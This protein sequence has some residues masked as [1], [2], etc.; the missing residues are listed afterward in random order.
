[1]VLQERGVSVTVSDDGHASASSMV[2]AGMW[3]PLSFKKLNHGWN[4]PALLD[5]AR[6]VYTKLERQL[7]CSFYH[8]TELVRVFPTAGQANE[9]T[10]RSELP[11]VA[12]YMADGFDREVADALKTPFGHGVV[13]QSGWMDVPVFLR[14][15]QVWLYKEGLMSPTIP[16][17]ADIVVN[18][19][20]FKAP[21]QP[22]WEWVPIYPN[23]GQVLRVHLP[24][25]HTRRMVN[26]GKFLVP[27]GNHDYRM[28][29]TYEYNDANPLPTPST[30]SAL[31]ADLCAAGISDVQVTDHRAGYRPTVPDRKPLIGMHPADPQKAIFGG[32]GSK[33]VMLVPWCAIEMADLLTHGRKVNAAVDVQRYFSK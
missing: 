12:P 31:L 17:S 3:N 8:P 9:W 22:G 6:T 24:T 25:L 21:H 16:E 11:A 13:K 32:F 29:A 4:V 1:M 26:F 19:T 7:Q 2:A 27:L 5:A 14:A 15:V 30:R 23:K 33:G 20:G 28:G 10:E 18:C